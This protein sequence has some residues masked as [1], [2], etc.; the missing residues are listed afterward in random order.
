MT[1]RVR[2]DANRCQ[3][4]TLCNATAPEVFHLREEDGHSYVESEEVPAELEEK[5]R[6]AA[7][8]CPEEAIVVVDE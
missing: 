8:A 3:G 1:M 2:V 5:V 6:R 4:H 7:R